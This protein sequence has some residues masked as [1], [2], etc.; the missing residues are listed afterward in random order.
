MKNL[1]AF[2]FASAAA[3]LVVACSSAPPPSSPDAA[4]GACQPSDCGPIAEIA[5]ICDDKSTGTPE[6][7]RAATG[8]CAWQHI[9]PGE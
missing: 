2:A 5:R 4:S 7:R 8:A 1:F 3:L 9:C 6:C